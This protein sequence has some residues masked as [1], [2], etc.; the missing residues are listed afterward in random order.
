MNRISLQLSKCEADPLTPVDHGEIIRLLAESCILR[1]LD[2]TSLVADRRMQ[3]TLIGER[4]GHGSMLGN[5]NLYEGT[6]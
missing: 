1:Y 5:T 4:K 6:P 3:S 2:E